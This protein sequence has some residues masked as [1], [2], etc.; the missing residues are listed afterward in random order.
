MDQRN[1][2]MVAEHGDDLFA[3]VEAHQAVVD[4]DAGELI[5]DGFVDQHGCHRGIDAAGKAADDLAGADLGADL[6]DHLGAIGS[7]I[8]IDSRP[9]I[10]CTKLARELAAIGRVH[11]FGVEHGGVVY[12]GSRRRDGEG[13]VG[14]GRR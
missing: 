2:V 8:P 10:L 3:L 4:I 14:R 6:L 5:A 9:T 7:H 11:H 1:I 13:G 12:G